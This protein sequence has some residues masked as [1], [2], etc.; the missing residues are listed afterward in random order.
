MATMWPRALPRQFVAIRPMLSFRVFVVVWLDT[1]SPVATVGA[2]KMFHPI[3][4]AGPLWEKIQYE[5]VR[6]TKIGKEK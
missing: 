2:A 4:G 3:D 5:Y 1:S 6:Y